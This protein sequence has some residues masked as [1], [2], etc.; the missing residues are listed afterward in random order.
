[1]RPAASLTGYTATHERGLAQALASALGSTAC[2]TRVQRPLPEKR[3]PCGHIHRVAAVSSC[4]DAGAFGGVGQMCVAAARNHCTSEM[5][6]LLQTHAALPDAA[7][8][9]VA[10]AFTPW[11]CSSMLV[12]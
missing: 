6:W 10:G 4:E 5:L 1:M 3:Q 9:G 7:L 12:R 11:M 2:G 8:Q